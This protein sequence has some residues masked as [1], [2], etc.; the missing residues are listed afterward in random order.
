MCRALTHSSWVRPLSRGAVGP[1]GRP[2]PRGGGGGELPRPGHGHPGDGDLRAPAAAGRRGSSGTTSVGCSSARAASRRRAGRRR[3]R[4][5]AWCRPDRAR[6]ARVPGRPRAPAD[7]GRSAG[8]GHASM[9]PHEPV[10]VAAPARRGAG[11]P[12]AAASG[13]MGAVTDFSAPARSVPADDVLVAAVE[14]ARA[15][16]VETAGD[17]Q[18]VGEHLGAT[19]GGRGAR[20]PARSRPRRSGAVLTHTFASRLP[21]YVGWH[22]AVTVTRVARRRRGDR[23]RGRAAARRLGAARAGLGA[24]ARAAAPRRPLRGRRAALHRGRPAARARLHRRRRL[25]RRPGGQRRRLRARAW[26]ASA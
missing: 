11:R 9:V 8:G 7:T 16:A 23:R 15:A 4:R 6:S 21:G 5:A 14:L 20:R 24:V 18:L 19:P 1:A 26:A 10:G 12:L 17:P 25:R 3:R 22:W 13:T 2:H